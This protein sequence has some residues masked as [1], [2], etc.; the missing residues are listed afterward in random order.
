MDLHVY[1]PDEE[2]PGK[3]A[4]LTEIPDQLETS[5]F[6]EETWQSILASELLKSILSGR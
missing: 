5:D 4:R 2:E 1:T 6:D 3:I